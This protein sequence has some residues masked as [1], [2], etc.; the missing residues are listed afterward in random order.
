MYEYR[1]YLYLKRNELNISILQIHKVLL[2]S[3]FPLLQRD[4][5]G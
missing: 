1:L 2:N 5:K 4:S 3:I